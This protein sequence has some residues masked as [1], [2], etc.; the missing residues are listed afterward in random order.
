MRTSKPQWI[1]E[2]EGTAQAE[3]LPTRDGGYSAA[4]ADCGGESGDV[5]QRCERAEA[6]RVGGAPRRRREE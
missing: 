3:E 1:W 5:S 2:H 6:A 4:Q